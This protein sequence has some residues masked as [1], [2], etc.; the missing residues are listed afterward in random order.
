M[1]Q[2]DSQ[3]KLPLPPPAAM[4]NEIPASPLK[5]ALVAGVIG[6]GAGYGVGK[7]LNEEG[8]PQTALAN[9]PAATLIDLDNDGVVDAVVIDENRD[10]IADA[11]AFDLNHDGKV[12]AVSVDTNKDGILDATSVDMNDDG[13]VDAV[14]VDSN[15]DGAIDAV[16]VDANQD[17]VIEAGEVTEIAPEV[18]DVDTDVDAGSIADLFT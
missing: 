18:P 2:D 4:P 6:L 15:A 7:L 9:H 8:Q 5:P 14:G 16:A 12:D 10:G 3:T 17:G 13:I 11:V 1:A